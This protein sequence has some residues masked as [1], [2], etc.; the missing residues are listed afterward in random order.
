M[1]WLW[2]IAALGAQTTDDRKVVPPP[3]IDMHFHAMTAAAMGPGAA[4]CSPY[5]GWPIRD[6][7]KPIEAYLGDF[8]MDPKCKVKFVAAKSD[9]ELTEANAR[10]LRKHN[11]I[12]LADGRQDRVAAID[13]LAPGRVLPAFAFGDGEN[14]PTLERLRELHRTGK[15]K[16]LSEITI[17]YAGI[18]PTDPRMAPY[19]ALAEELDLPVG[20][21]MGPGPPGVSPAGGSRWTGERHRHC[22]GVRSARG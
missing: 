12:A 8:T 10:I 6:P 19:W 16:S 1:S 4:I 13:A 15:I 11:M 14:W 17:Q 7:G 20:I 22:E 18:K 2:M 21:H 9:D 3:I 5:E